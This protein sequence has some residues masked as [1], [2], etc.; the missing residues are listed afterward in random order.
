MGRSAFGC[1]ASK[2]IR[3]FVC[4]KLPSSSVSALSRWIALRRA[5]CP[6]VRWVSADTIHITLKFCGEIE[7][8]TVGALCAQLGKEDLGNAFRLCISGIGG[9]PSLSSPRVIWAGIKGQTAELRR[10]WYV[11]ENCARSFG[12]EEERRFSPHITLGRRKDTAP[13]GPAFAAALLKDAIELPE[14]TVE[15][16]IMMESKLTP[17]GAIHTPLERFPLKKLLI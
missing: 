17:G 5:E 7:Q 13:P 16:I 4:A 12:I 2:P 11:V 1:G 10:L 3:V 6:G 15:E 8:N 9:F 14:W